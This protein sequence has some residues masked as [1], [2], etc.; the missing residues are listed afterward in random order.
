MNPDAPQTSWR[1]IY[2]YCQ[3]DTV[4]ENNCV[5]DKLD[6]LFILDATGSMSDP[7][8]NLKSSLSS[9]VASIQTKFTSGYRMALMQVVDEPNYPYYIPVSFSDNNESEM[10]AALDGIYPGDGGERPEPTDVALGGALD[11]EAGYFRKTNTAKVIF[12]ITDAIPWYLQEE[13]NST[14][15]YRPYIEY[16][17]NKAKD[18]GVTVFPIAVG[19]GANP[20]HADYPKVQEAHEI[21]SSITG[22]V[23]YNKQDGVI[24]SDI[25]DAIDYSSCEGASRTYKV[26]TGYKGFS[27][28]EEV[29][30]GTGQPTGVVKNNDPEDPDYVAP[31]YDEGYCERG[32]LYITLA[33]NYTE[34]SLDGDVV[35]VQVY[36]NTVW[37]VV[38]RSPWI[39][40]DIQSEY[41]HDDLAR[42]N[43]SENTGEERV[44]RFEV[45]T[46]DGSIIK[47]F[48][49]RQAGVVTLNSITLAIGASGNSA[50]D[51]Y[52]SGTHVI[53]YI[54]GQNLTDSTV[55]ANN[56]SGT[57]AASEGWYSDGSMKRYWT[58]SSFTGEADVC[59]F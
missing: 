16:L 31:V 37:Q 52:N 18:E 25:I 34:K 39:T 50:C 20:N 11:G 21:Y 54:D 53:R 48:I 30:N 6:V 17:S 22:G 27:S 32:E 3:T 42:V 23:A 10:Q 46:S 57:D 55:L 9:I 29:D 51:N 59:G 5:E 38:S 47:E 56:V 26:N 2:P 14:P 8:E 13:D 35:S 24:E 19:F 7:I 15:L 40:V 49:I 45:R 44:G 12:I 4:T 36:S 33:N 58:G 43:I 41:T 28:I 1:G